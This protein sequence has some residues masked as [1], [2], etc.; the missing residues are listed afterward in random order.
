MRI[1]TI[2]WLVSATHCQ[3]RQIGVFFFSDTSGTNSTTSVGTKGCGVGG[4]ERSQERQCISGA[5]GKLHLVRPRY[6]RSDMEALNQ[7]HMSNA[8]CLFLQ[9]HQLHAPY[10]GLPDCKLLQLFGKHLQ[11]FTSHL[12]SFGIEF[13]LEHRIFYKRPTEIKREVVEVQC[14]LGFLFALNRSDANTSPT[15]SHL[16]IKFNTDNVHQ[17]RNISAWLRPNAW[18]QKKAR[19][20]C[21][22]IYMMSYTW[23]KQIPT[24]QDSQQW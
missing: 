18:S 4:A 13:G 10:D 7:N 2:H 22:T 5:Y 11:L 14:Y 20:F 21:Q 9:T 1:L 8:K 3:P 17:L 16:Q 15:W 12:F 6:M 23:S 19:T 24:K